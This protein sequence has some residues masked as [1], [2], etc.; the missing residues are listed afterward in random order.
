MTEATA[1]TAADTTAAPITDTATTAVPQAQPPTTAAPDWTSG[2]TDEATRSWVTSKGYKDPSALAQSALNLEKLIG[3]PADRI[4]KL[5]TDANAAEWDQVYAKLG[6]PE[7]ADKYDLP[8]PE[9]DAGDFAKI[10]KDWFHKAGLSA[11][12]ARSVA[13]QWNG[14][15]SELSKAQTVKMQQEH[16]AQINGLKNEWGGEYQANT[17][18]VDRAAEAFGMTGE[19]LTALKGA[20]GPAAAMKFMHSLG[21]KVALP[22]N[23]LVNGERTGSFGGVSPE[24]ARAEIASLKGDKAFSAQYTSKDDKTR[25]EAREKMNRLHQIAY[26]G[27]FTV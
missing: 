18:I 25:F 11:S 7:T 5:P 8:I 9:G 22:A 27:A 4:V 26:P 21:S 10:A 16:E 13:E 1:A 24:Q 17:E 23:G 6:R 2:I 3:A 20:M 14:H 19:Q 15:V 12:M